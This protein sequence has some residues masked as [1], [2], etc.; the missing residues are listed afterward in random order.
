VPT[1]L[2]VGLTLL[3]SWG[4]TSTF[5]LQDD[6]IRYWNT[7]LLPLT[8]Q[9]LVGPSTHYGGYALGPAFYWVLWLTRVTFGPFVDNLPHAG[10]FGQILLASAADAVLLVALWRRTGS[11]MLAL[12]TVL[13]IATAPFDLALSA[14][15]WNPIMAAIAIKAATALVLLGWAERSLPYAATTTGLAWTSVHANL[16]AIFAVGGIFAA[17][18]VPPLLQRDY[19]TL[20]RRAA[21]IAATVGCLQLPYL[22]HRIWVDPGGGGI[23]V[24]TASLGRILTGG[25]A[26]RWSESAAAL[27]QAVNRIQ[28]DPWQAGWVGWMLALCAVFVAVRYRHDVPLVSVTVLPL[29]AA[30][31][32]YAFWVRDFDDYYYLSLMPARVLTF[33]S[34]V[35]GLT[36]VTRGRVATGAAVALLVVAIAIMPARVRQS[37]TFHRMPGYD[38]LVAGSRQILRQ[39]VSVREIRADFLPPDSNS[40]FIYRVL[41]GTIDPDG[42]WIASVEPDGVVSY[43]QVSRQ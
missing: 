23:E 14:T 36:T 26:L 33:Q 28:I 6:Q 10:A 9:P 31:V 15:I 5:L 32:G 21:T 29:A 8:E 22:A 30:L 1:A 39:N 16:P 3:R 40:E 24:I 17:I 4:I 34:T 27:G 12:A 42:G 18:V 7:A 25:E 35:S 19:R 2:F 43:E 41:G 37:T 13:L 20:W 38:G 11:V